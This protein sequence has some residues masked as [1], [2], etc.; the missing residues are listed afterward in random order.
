[1]HR[2]TLFC[3]CVRC[4]LNQGSLNW[5]FRL[6]TIDCFG[7][8]LAK[9]AIIIC[10]CRTSIDLRLPEPIDNE[11]ERKKRTNVQLDFDIRLFVCLCDVCRKKLVPL[12]CLTSCTLFVNTT[13]YPLLI[14]GNE[15]TANNILMK[16]KRRSKAPKTGPR[17]CTMRL[18]RTK[19]HFLKMKSHSTSGKNLLFQRM[20]IFYELVLK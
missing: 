20:M 2:C 11:K 16:D 5:N 18:L 4:C 15:K 1:M 19:S 9:V 6:E 10:H 13:I 7:L 8:S 12:Y 17:L 14:F 3:L